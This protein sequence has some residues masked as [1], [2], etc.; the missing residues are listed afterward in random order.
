MI[1]TSAVMLALALPASPLAAQARDS[2]QA[3]PPAGER[4]G[5]GP[6]FTANDAWLALGFVAGTVAMAPLDR[7]LAG[8]LQDSTLQVHQ[9]L[10]GLAG[11][12]RVL[13][14]PGTAVLGSSA[15]VL[16]RVTDRPR[17]AA[18]GLHATEAVVLSY[19]FVVTGKTL[20][21]RARPVLDVDDPFDFKL[22]RGGR[23]DDFASFPSGH[24]AAAFAA[25]AAV[26][27]ET[28][29]IWPEATRYAAPVLYGGAVVVG[30]SRMYHNRHWAS[31]V[32]AGAAIGT[33]SGLKVV[34]YHYRRP[35]NAIDRWLLPT[36]VVPA[37]SGLLLVW[38]L[39]APR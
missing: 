33:F 27:A 19:A 36:A 8:T 25:A 18:I 3:A 20:L 22:G 6:F 4:S 34:K 7:G 39:P 29:E 9:V 2:A 5:A 28:R 26:T 11:T 21:G 31:D 15:Y 14:F 10:R 12:F 30:V 37:E 13:G 38:V 1:R 23:S 24:T 17:M 35:D 16:G 32:M